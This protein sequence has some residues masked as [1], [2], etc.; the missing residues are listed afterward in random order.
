MFSDMEISISRK[1]SSKALH[2][3]DSSSRQPSIEVH[4]ADKSRGEQ[5]KVSSESCQQQEEEPALDNGEHKGD[6]N[7][8]IWPAGYYYQDSAG[9]TQGPCSLQ[10][11][12]ALHACFPEAAAMTIWA[13]DGSGGGYSVQLYEVLAWAAP[14]PQQQQL[15]HTWSCSSSH[16]AAP[17]SEH[18]DGAS[19]QHASSQQSLASSC[20][21]AE[22]VLAGETLCVTTCHASVSLWGLQQGNVPLAALPQSAEASILVQGCQR[23]MRQNS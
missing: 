23:M 1:A 4:V 22:A 5:F 12:Q 3:D 6:T 13:G 21:Y 11:L 7:T 2:N 15:L 20:K 17:P 16:I 19:A 10:D 14:Q 18:Q 8:V 9:N